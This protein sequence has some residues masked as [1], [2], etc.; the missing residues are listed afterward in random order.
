MN[1]QL[2]IKESIFKH[3]SESP[4]HSVFF[5][6]DFAELGSVETIRKALKEAA[7]QGLVDHIAHGIYAKPMLS[8]FGIVPIPLEIVAKEIAIRDRVQ[9]MPTGSTA[10]NILGLSTQI[11]MVVSF[12]TTGSSRNI[13][14]G[15]RLIKFRH[16][17]P[18]NFS[19][20]GFTIPLV[21]QA[22]KDIEKENI[23]EEELSIVKEYISKAFDKQ[24]II[25]DILMAPQ[26]I[27]TILKQYINQFKQA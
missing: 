24:A 22:F 10:A 21:I 23:G 26:W 13:K 19:F 7:N 8:K 17:A 4:N 6:G 3:I 12:L 9:I 1:E 18:R 2:G 16:A 27:Q 15:K 25:H 20:E 5:I 11:P 14:I